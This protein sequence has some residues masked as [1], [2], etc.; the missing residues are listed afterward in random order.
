MS[1]TRNTFGI[2]KRGDSMK[3]SNKSNL[4]VMVLFSLCAV[5]FDVV[6][7]MDIVF[8]RSDIMICVLHGI[9]AVLWTGMAVGQI[10]RYKNNR[11]S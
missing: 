6:F 2:D 10:C 4:T 9:C 8:S 11:D 5:I 1:R 7:V 3:S